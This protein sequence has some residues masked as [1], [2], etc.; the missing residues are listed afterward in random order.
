MEGNNT[1]QDICSV[2]IHED[3]MAPSG[4][5]L[6]KPVAFGLIA[7]VAGGIIIYKAGWLPF[8]RS[9]SMAVTDSLNEGMCCLDIY[10]VI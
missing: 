2:Y 8:S 5:T 1:D 3:K 7:L 6:N 4:L 10:F 9:H